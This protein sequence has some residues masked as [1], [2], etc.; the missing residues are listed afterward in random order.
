MIDSAAHRQRWLFAAVALTAFAIYLPTIRC[1]FVWD[2]KALIV[3]NQYLA[4]ASAPSVF[5]HNYW[6]NPDLPAAIS[7]K[8]LLPAARPDVPGEPAPG[9]TGRQGTT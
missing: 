9:G 7:D 4:E 6:Y 1:G 3:E 5:A 8:G 2:D